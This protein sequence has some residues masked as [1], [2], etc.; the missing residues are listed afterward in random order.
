MAKVNINKFKKHLKLVS[1]ATP[2]GEPAILMVMAYM[3]L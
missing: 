2:G 3:N 1:D